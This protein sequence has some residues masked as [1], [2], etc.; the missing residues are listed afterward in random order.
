[1]K[2]YSIIRETA[3]FVKIY[4]TAKTCRATFWK[5]NGSLISDTSAEARFPHMTAQEVVKSDS[6]SQKRRKEVGRFGR[7]RR[8]GTADEKACLFALRSRRVNA[9]MAARTAA[10]KIRPGSFPVSESG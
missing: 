2:L 7:G 5:I 9:G 4:T 8:T 3:L 6:A 10:F 1:M